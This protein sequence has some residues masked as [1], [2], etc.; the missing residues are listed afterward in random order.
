MHPIVKKQVR[1]PIHLI[2][3]TNT[4]TSYKL[5]RHIAKHLDWS[6]FKAV[7]VYFDGERYIIT[8]GNHRVLGAKKAGHTHVPAILLTEAEF[9]FVAYSKNTLDFLVDPNV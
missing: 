7:P 8:D 6:L 9:E 5:V 4:K 3:I 2:T 1:I